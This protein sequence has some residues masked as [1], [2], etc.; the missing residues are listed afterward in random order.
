[1]AAP[2][3]FDV[4][5]WNSA[6][7][8]QPSRSRPNTRTP[9]AFP[10]AKR[11]KLD[12]SPTTPPSNLPPSLRNPSPIPFSKALPGY[13]SI[14]SLKHAP[15][16]GIPTSTTSTSPRS[17]LLQR[18]EKYSTGE[19]L[20]AL[21]TLG[22]NQDLE[23]SPIQHGGLLPDIYMLSPVSINPLKQAHRICGFAH[24]IEMTGTHPVDVP[25]SRRTQC[26]FE[27]AS[28]ESI[29]IATLPS[30]KYSGW[31]ESMTTSAK[32]QGVR[33]VIVNGFATDLIAHREAGFSVFA[34]AYSP[35]GKVI[36]AFP[37]R[38]GVPVIFSPRSHFGTY[39]KDSLSAVKVCPGDIIV[40]D[41][42]GAVCPSSLGDSI[43]DADEYGAELGKE[44]RVWRVYV[45]ET[46][47]WDEE[48]VDGWNKS[49]DVILV[50]AALF[51]A[52]S[53][54][55]IVE[56][57]KQLQ[58]D[59]S[60]VTAETLVTI[61]QILLAIVNNTQLI[62]QVQT[63]GLE[64]GGMPSFNPPRS[65]VIINTLW[66]MSLS[67][68]LAT[69]LLA[70]LAKDWCHSFKSNR[71]GHPWSQTIRRQK[72]WVMIERWKMQELI[73]VLPSL[74]HLSLLLFSVG[75]SIYV[76]DLNNSVA[77]PVICIFGAALAF[78]ILSSIVASVVPF[79][80]YTTIISRMWKSEGFT[81]LIRHPIKSGVELVRC[82]LLTH[83]VTL[84]LAIAAALTVTLYQINGIYQSLSEVLGCFTVIVLAYIPNACA[85][86]FYW[87]YWVFTAIPGLL[88][89]IPKLIVNLLFG[90]IPQAVLSRHGKPL[91][92]GTRDQNW[93]ISEA[94]SWI[95]KYCETPS[96]VEVALQAIAGAS[97]II[98]RKPLED[99]QASMK[100]LQRLVSSASYR[101]NTSAHLSL[102]AR[103]YE[104]LSAPAQE[105]TYNT[106]T[107][108]D[109]EVMI[110]DLQSKNE[111]Y[112]ARLITQSPLQPSLRN[113]EALRISSSAASQALQL[114]HKRGE[115]ATI[116]SPI[117][118]LSSEYIIGGYELHMAVFTSIVNT[119][120]LL[121]ACSPSHHERGVSSELR[122]AAYYSCMHLIAH[123]RKRLER[124]TPVD[125]WTSSHL[126]LCTF[127]QLD[128][129]H[130][131]Q[132]RKNNTSDGV[133]LHSSKNSVLA[134]LNHYDR[135]QKTLS[136]VNL[137]FF[138]WVGFSEILSNP[139]DYGLDDY[140]SIRKI[141]TDLDL[142]MSNEPTRR[143][144]SLYNH[145][146][147]FNRDFVNN[148]ESFMYEYYESHSFLAECRLGRGRQSLG[149]F[150]VP[151]S[152]PPGVPLHTPR[153]PN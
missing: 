115:A 153:G 38:I 46:D 86:L 26:L 28:S 135:S 80:P 91:T 20:Y 152:Y 2:A 140:E 48:L 55:F 39:F 124:S 22:L 85:Q 103:A 122:S 137:D 10:R 116:F 76:L 52:V 102:Y 117:I 110:W 100:I 44:A 150:I 68:S 21:I 149:S 118:R 111:S 148:G 19:I 36:A 17:L 43:V 74:I 30:A 12:P 128:H 90:L 50:F 104:F 109:L 151:S 77:V 61:S 54:A 40:A 120:A 6:H 73:L 145:F 16:T 1:M 33:G 45:K 81:Y 5:I 147:R 127:S 75:L 97:P 82:W 87:P 133:V 27:A 79:F 13:N 11:Q 65:A 121:F 24:T 41:V 71:S 64:K 58:Q 92:S 105:D 112:I 14:L 113:L 49:L 83:L 9:S 96:S 138:T 34:Q 15:K 125:Y 98:P 70:M 60:E 37:S 7:P 108:G 131:H 93:T 106:K 31:D 130:N 47:R 119:V 25:R 101:G 69:S 136:A 63:M 134:L 129:G 78:Y 95:I 132:T 141:L 146:P 139:D 32:N 72:K 23:D 3:N 18:L 4:W 56:S 99:C 29:I 53:T 62:P 143:I 114:L 51:S 123:Y 94:L 107:A 57:S 42:G 144:K 89:R 59:P 8:E 84:N 88:L 126:V 35:P 142:D 66:Y 67:L